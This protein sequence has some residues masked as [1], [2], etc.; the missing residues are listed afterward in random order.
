MTKPYMVKIICT[1]DGEET[2]ITGFGR[3]IDDNVWANTAKRLVKRRFGVFPKDLK[4]TDLETITFEGSKDK[5]GYDLKV[6]TIPC[7]VYTCTI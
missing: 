5:V 3:E 1:K 7:Y 6:K 2:E 4:N